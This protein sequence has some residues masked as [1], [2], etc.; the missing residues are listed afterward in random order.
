MR[1]TPGSRSTGSSATPSATTSCR[2]R[3]PRTT[4]S[5]TRCWSERVDGGS[6]VGQRAV[7]RAGVATGAVGDGA[8]ARRKLT[9]GHDRGP[10]TGVGRTDEDG[11]QIGDLLADG[12]SG[13]VVDPLV[14]GDGRIESVELEDVEPAG[15]DPSAWPAAPARHG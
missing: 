9:A 4:A 11:V 15:R 2:P 8:A 3:R 10:E 6:G 5:S 1:S 13:R 12:G 7:D 14:V